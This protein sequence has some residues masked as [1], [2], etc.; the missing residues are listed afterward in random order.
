MISRI[1]SVWDSK[2]M[3][4]SSPFMFENVGHA[5]REFG[6]AANSDKSYISKHP[7]DYTLFEL[8]MFDNLTAK[9]DLYP[10]PR[11]S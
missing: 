10:T 9:Y 5:I 3:F 7:E 6:D 4:Y 8:G 1:F 2:G 11:L